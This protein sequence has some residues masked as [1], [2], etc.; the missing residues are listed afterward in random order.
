MN[1]PIANYNY[2]ASN[3]HM[4]IYQISPI[5]VQNTPKK[6]LMNLKRLG[7]SFQM[8]MDRCLTSRRLRCINAV[9]TSVCHRLSRT[10]QSA[11]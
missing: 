5:L 6:K 11:M 4:K 8:L 9:L 10:V 7:G 2:E 3:L 1:D